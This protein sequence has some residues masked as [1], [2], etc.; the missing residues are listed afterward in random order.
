MRLSLISRI[1]IQHFL[2]LMPFIGFCLAALNDFYHNVVADYS[3]TPLTKTYWGE[4]NDFM[5]PTGIILLLLMILFKHLTNTLF[6]TELDAARISDMKKGTEAEQA[7][8]HGSALIFFGGVLYM[9]IYVIF[10]SPFRQL[11]N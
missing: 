3:A 4:L 8:Y 5:Y 11:L 1:P 7:F 2:F 6:R 9:L 10:G